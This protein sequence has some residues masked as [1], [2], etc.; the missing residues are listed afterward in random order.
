MNH[1]WATGERPQ[2]PHSMHADHAHQA[3]TQALQGA[4]LS[5]LAAS[6]TLHCLSG[7]AIGEVLGMVIGTALGWS[8]GETIALAVALA[9]VIAATN[10]F[11]WNRLWVYPESRTQKKRRQMPIFLA[12][13]AAGLLINELIFLLFQTPITELIRIVPIP[14]IQ[15]H[16]RGIGLNVTKLIAAV[17]VMLWNFFVNRFVTFRN[18]KWK[19]N[20]AV[21]ARPEPVD[22][23]L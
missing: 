18:V 7:C 5:R 16:Y 8:N 4:A 19:R 2:H 15:S 22:S 20:P 9:F 6:A 14:F 1:A 10:N 3:P 12:V 11:I 17:I 21:E 23:V 13:N